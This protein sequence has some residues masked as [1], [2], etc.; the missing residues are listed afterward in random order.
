[1]FSASRFKR[2][3]IDI[4][5]RL[6]SYAQSNNI[7]VLTSVSMEAPPRPLLLIVSQRSLYHFDKIVLI[8]SLR[9]RL[10]TQLAT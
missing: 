5:V 6:I 7:M 1:M 9:R 10:D 4:A 8:I 3:Q 2:F